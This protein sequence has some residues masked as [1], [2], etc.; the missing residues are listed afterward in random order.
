MRVSFMT[1]WENMHD[2]PDAEHIDTASMKAIRTGMNISDDFW[3]NFMQVCNNSEALGELL[4]VRPDQVA[5]WGGRI[6]HNLHRVQQADTAG[7]GDDKPKTKV[8]D[9]GN[10]LGATAHM[11][12]AIG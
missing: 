8:M 4:G 6:K 2:T 11:P 1:L 5:G 3:D 12:P 10:D 7:D 9:T